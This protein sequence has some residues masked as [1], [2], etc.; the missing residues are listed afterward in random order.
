MADELAEEFDRADFGV[1]REPV[2]RPAAE[3]H[4]VRTKRDRHLAIGTAGDRDTPSDGNVDLA[5]TVDFDRH[6][7]AA[8]AAGGPRRG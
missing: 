6:M 7:P 4:R 1:E 5:K 3:P 8:P 2:D